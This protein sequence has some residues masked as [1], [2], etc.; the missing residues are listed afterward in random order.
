MT[1]EPNDIHKVKLLRNLCRLR[2][3][4]MMDKA[5]AM[6]SDVEDLPEDLVDIDRQVDAEVYEIS[7][8]YFQLSLEK[9]ELSFPGYP[10]L[11]DVLVKALYAYHRY[12]GVK[13][14]FYYP[15]DWPPESCLDEPIRGKESVQRMLF[16]AIA[17]SLVYLTKRNAANINE[18]LA[19][20]ADT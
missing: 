7:R 11:V 15:A 5:S 19:L 10:Q 13:P 3:S 18:P 4:Q 14:V 12:A 6:N 1:E 16:E 8:V 9:P 2:F 20:R 17:E